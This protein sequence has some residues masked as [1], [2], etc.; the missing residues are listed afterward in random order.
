MPVNLVSFKCISD[1]RKENRRGC[2]FHCNKHSL[3]Y[4]RRITQALN[5]IHI[6]VFQDMTSCCHWNV[7]SVSSDLWCRS[8]EDGGTNLHW[9]GYLRCQNLCMFCYNSRIVSLNCCQNCYFHLINLLLQVKTNSFDIADVL[10]TPMKQ[11]SLT[12]TEPKLSAR[13]SESI[14]CVSGKFRVQYCLWSEL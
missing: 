10:K 8:L 11:K 13:Y 9:Q 7:L 4:C 1:N 3:W 12:F 5:F 14:I 2:T 6:V